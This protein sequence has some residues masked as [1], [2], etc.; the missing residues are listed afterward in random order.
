MSS[1]S[2]PPTRK[3]RN[4]VTPYRMP[5][6]LWSTVVIQLHRPVGSACAAMCWWGA[7][8]VAVD[9]IPA[10]SGF[11]ARP[12]GFGAPDHERPCRGMAPAAAVAVSM[13]RACA[14]LKRLQVRHD[15]GD[16]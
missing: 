8:T 10:P 9:A 15:V 3:N 12:L 7:A 4:A 1:A 2:T 6:R 5:M 11:G 16:L 13:S 14:L